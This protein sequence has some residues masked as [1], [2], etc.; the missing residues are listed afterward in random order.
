VAEPARP[1]R[2]ARPARLYILTGL[3]GAGKTTYTRR[4]LADAV[5][6]SLDDLRLMMSGVAYDPRYE[7]IVAASA[8]ALLDVLLAQATGEGYDVVFDATNVT[9]EWRA[10]AIG[11]ARRHGVEPHAIYF[12]V[13]LAVA[14]A[15]NRA[16]AQAVPDEVLRR[17]AEK[18]E[19]PTLDEGFAAIVVV[20]EDREGR[21]GRD[22]PVDASHSG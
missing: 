18:L 17:F 2:P 10:R 22:A 15:R 11:Q 19:P 8:T 6:V 21:S 3:P 12:A 14:A 13:P 9:R 4:E 5:R 7:P 1:D 20:G 16:R